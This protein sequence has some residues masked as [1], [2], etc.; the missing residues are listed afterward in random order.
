MMKKVYYAHSIAIYNTP[1]EARDIDTLTKLGFEVVNPNAPEHEA[2]YKRMGMDYFTAMIRDC[3]ALAFRA[4]PDGTIN[5][6]IA[7]EIEDALDEPSLP[8]FELPSGINRRTLTVGQT[9][10]TLREQGAR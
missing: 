9:R 6:G 8:V 4:N 5:A 7:K 10:A 1:Q 2:G 3:D